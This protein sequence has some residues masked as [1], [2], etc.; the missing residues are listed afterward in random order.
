[1][2]KQ[3]RAE[4]NNHDDTKD[5]SHPGDR[6]A[7][8]DTYL[9]QFIERTNP[10]ECPENEDNLHQS[11]NPRSTH[12]EQRNQTKRSKNTEKILVAHEMGAKNDKT[13]D[14]RNVNQYFL[15]NRIMA[16]DDCTWGLVTIRTSMVR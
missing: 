1:L 16:D 9:Y 15:H 13:E 14:D 8:R 10:L 11:G 3:R 4:C 5:D 12:K 2:E 6:L 7:S